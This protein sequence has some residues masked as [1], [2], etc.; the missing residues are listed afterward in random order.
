MIGPGAMEGVE[1]HHL[2][3]MV[4]AGKRRVADR[5][6][7]ESLGKRRLSRHVEVLVTEEDDPMGEQG[8]SDGGSMAM[9]S[10]PGGSIS[11][12]VLTRVVI[13]LSSI[14]HRDIGPAL[15]GPGVV[16]SDEIDLIEYNVTRFPAA[17]DREV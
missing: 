4:G 6:R 5:Q 1:L 2:G 14:R 17:A 3:E 15:P 16:S 9:A 12:S 7:T 11:S 8:L 13:A 10:A